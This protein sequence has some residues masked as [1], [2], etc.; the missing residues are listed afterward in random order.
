MRL[1]K[2]ESKSSAKGSGPGR[3]VIHDLRSCIAIG[4]KLG[5]MPMDLSLEPAIKATNSICDDPTIDAGAAGEEGALCSSTLRKRVPKLMNGT[6]WSKLQREDHLDVWTHILRTQYPECVDS[7][8]YLVKLV[9]ARVSMV[10]D[11]TEALPTPVQEESP[12]PNDPSQWTMSEATEDTDLSFV[13]ITEHLLEFSTSEVLVW[14]P[15]GIGLSHQLFGDD[16]A[17][18]L[19]QPE[20]AAADALT[21]ALADDD[22]A[23]LDASVPLLDDLDIDQLPNASHSAGVLESDLDRLLNIFMESDP[24]EGMDLQEM[25]LL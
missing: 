24:M 17:C 10:N 11:A 23:H 21:G 25:P 22:L 6:T 5:I 15:P 19:P 7:I 18:S 8:L 13:A 1:P 20:E 2:T 9:C 14:P 12:P 16:E 3:P 4:T